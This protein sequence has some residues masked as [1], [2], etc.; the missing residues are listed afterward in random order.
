MP[1][2]WT[3]LLVGKMHNKKITY[4]MLASRLGVTKGYVSMVLNGARK[5]AN[6]EERFTAAL[7]ELRRALNIKARTTVLR[8]RCPQLL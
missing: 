4:G 5:P 6:A 7:D 3:G 2:A 8:T 1:D